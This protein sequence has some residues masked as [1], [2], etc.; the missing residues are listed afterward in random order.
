[1]DVR[2]RPGDDY[3]EINAAGKCSDTARFQA[4]LIRHQKG[5]ESVLE[6]GGSFFGATLL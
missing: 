3:G 1:M 4:A 5:R 2:V 6:D